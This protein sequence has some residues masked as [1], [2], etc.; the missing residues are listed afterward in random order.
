D[1]HLY[2]NRARYLNTSTGRFWSMDSF[3]GE[4]ESPQSLHKYLFASADP[5]NRIDPSGN[6]DIASLTAAGAIGNTL[7]NLTAIQGQTVMDQLQF[8]GNAGLKSILIATGFLVGGEVVLKA[9]GG[10]VRRISAAVYSLD[11]KIACQGFSRAAEF[12][13]LPFEELAE[14][15]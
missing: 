13:V 2:Y 6:E 3:E 8:G 9:V 12:G 11:A 5:P 10:V 4:V 7:N 14:V 15:V 1:L